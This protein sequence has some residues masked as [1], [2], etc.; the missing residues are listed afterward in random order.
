[1]R[2]M[3]RNGALALALMGSTAF[4]ANP[5]FALDPDPNPPDGPELVA[6]PADLPDFQ[7]EWAC[8]DDQTANDRDAPDIVVGFTHVECHCPRCRV[9]SLGRS[10]G[11]RA[12]RWVSPSRSCL[13][14][15]AARNVAAR[16]TRSSRGD[17]QTFSP[18]CLGTLSSLPS[19]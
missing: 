16:C 7:L 1:M 5:S 6:P 8:C 4:L 13:S 3:L 14:D 17:C 11:F 2:N 12:S 10:V 15:C 19:F 9:T 18:G